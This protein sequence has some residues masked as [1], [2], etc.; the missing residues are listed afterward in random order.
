MEYIDQGLLRAQAWK[1]YCCALAW[2]LYLFLIPYAYHLLG[3]WSMVF[4]I[5]PGAWLFA[6][7][8]YLMH[9]S[10]H[11][12]VP[13]VPADLFFYIFGFMLIIDP[14][15][16]R[17]AHGTHHAEVHTW[18]DVE[19]HPWGRIAPGTRRR[20]YNL[21]EIV[22]GSI[23]MQ[24]IT[25]VRVPFLPQFEK[26]YRLWLTLVSPLVWLIFLGGL[27]WASWR[28]FGLVHTDVGISYMLAYFWGSF[29]QHNSQLVEHGNIIAAGDWRERNLKARNLRPEGILEKVFLFLTHN[30]SRE[31]V[32]H[33]TLVQVYSRPFPGRV[34]LPAE[35]EFI[36]LRDYVKIAWGMIT[37][38]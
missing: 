9:E 27:G 1:F 16:Y 7:V 35:A 17:L 11:R 3:G 5:F 2:P 24:F 37:K 19:F 8:A 10:W 14:Q 34:P 36:N 21:L 20:L 26:R 22:F 18:N 30:D 33:H 15:I 29:I 12:Y 31:H 28:V 6:W 38:G 13:N 23:F 4:M 32:L 25:T